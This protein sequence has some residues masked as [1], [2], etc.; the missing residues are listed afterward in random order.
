MNSGYGELVWV[1]ME[2]NPYKTTILYALV[3]WCA[4]DFGP[5]VPWRGVDERM[6]KMFTPGK[7]E[8]LWQ[9]GAE[10]CYLRAIQGPGAR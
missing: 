9:K 5:D 3:R 8:N 2:R 10:L 1:R 6:G 4:G 7:L